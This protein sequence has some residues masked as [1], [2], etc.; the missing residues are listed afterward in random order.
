MDHSFNRFLCAGV[1]D[2]GILDHFT[3]C[4]SIP[5]P[6]ELLDTVYSLLDP[7]LYWRF[8]GSVSRMALEWVSRWHEE[9]RCLKPCQVVPVLQY[10]GSDPVCWCSARHRIS[11]QLLITGSDCG[12]HE[13]RRRALIEYFI[14]NIR[15]NTGID[16]KIDY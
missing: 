8:F 10:P 16:R 7:G 5:T 15:I 2:P 6:K 13:Q 3:L 14:E 1:G 9:R 11:Q 12:A 4:Q